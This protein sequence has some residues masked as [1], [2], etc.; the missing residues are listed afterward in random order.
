MKV[1]ILGAGPAGAS[2]AIELCKIGIEIVLVDVS[3][4]P[5][6]TPGESCHPGIEP[7]LIQLGVMEK[8]ITSN[9]FRFDGIWINKNG[10]LRKEFF[11]ESENWQGFHF[12]R[13]LF[14][15]ILL[16]EAIRL[17]TKFIP[18]IKAIDYEVKSNAITK[19]K[20]NLGIFAADFFIDATG[21][22]CWSAQR[23]N[24]GRKVL[25]DKIYSWYC[26]IKTDEI[27]DQKYEAYYE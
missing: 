3:S 7:L 5:R 14:D 2:C 25:S 6:F 26:R 15:T 18:N 17:G 24:I 20:S 23:L 27:V 8:I 13:E 1:F 10:E 21:R 19:I 16:D 12:N 11:N 22:K 4:F 9:P